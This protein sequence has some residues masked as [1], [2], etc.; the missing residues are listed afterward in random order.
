MSMRKL[1]PM[2]VAEQLDRSRARPTEVTGSSDDRGGGYGVDIDANYML[3]E[4][5]RRH[6]SLEKAVAHLS[7]PRLRTACRI[8][9]EIFL[10]G[11]W[12]ELAN[13]RPLQRGSIDRRGR[14]P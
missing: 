12:P 14:S 11:R 10:A 3:V 9:G 2:T 1:H 6:R 4:D 7:V 13:G 5:P 8:G